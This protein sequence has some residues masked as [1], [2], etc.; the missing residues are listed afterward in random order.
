MNL[1]DVKPNVKERVIDLV[2]K[3]GIAVD[4]RS[5]KASGEAFK[6]N[7]AKNPNYC[8]VWCFRDDKLKIALLNVWFDSMY[9]DNGTIKQNINIWEI[10]KETLNKQG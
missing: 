9:M 2:K 4:D 1:N 3:A 5:V 10:G 6:G 8:Y 7:P